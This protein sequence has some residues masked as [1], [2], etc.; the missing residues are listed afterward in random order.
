MQSIQT[1][2]RA[3][4]ECA[5]LRIELVEFEKRVKELQ[6]SLHNIEWEVHSNSGQSPL[7]REDRL[8]TRIEEVPARIAGA[9]SDSGRDRMRYVREG[10]AAKYIGVSVSTPRSWRT[11]R[12][13]NGPPYTRLGRLVTYRIAELDEHMKARTVPQ[14]S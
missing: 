8:V 13:K 6:V 9:G 7:H 12:S 3:T 11:K 1:F 5:R 10:E 4:T 14:R 2:E